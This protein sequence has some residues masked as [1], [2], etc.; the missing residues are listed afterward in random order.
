MD[1]PRC[2]LRSDQLVNQAADLH[3]QG[4]L[5]AAES[6]Y[7]QV[8]YAQSDHF[9]V[10]HS[11]GV[12]RYQQGRF[13][14]ALSLIGA[15]LKNNPDFP[16]ALVNY[17][18]VLQALDR[19]V[20]ALASYDRALWIKPDYAESLYN[21]GNA[22]QDY[23]RGEI[24]QDLYCTA[25]DKALAIQP[26]AVDVLNHR[27]TILRDLKRLAEALASYDKALEIKP[28]YAEALNNRGNVLRDL[29]RSD[30]PLAS[31]DKGFIFSPAR[32]QSPMTQQDYPGRLQV[33]F[34]YGYATDGPVAVRQPSNH[35]KQQM[36]LAVARAFEPRR[37]VGFGKVR[38]GRDFDGGYV[39]VDDFAGVGAALSCGI[40][41]DA[42]WDL[43]IAK[44]N[45]PV[46]QFDHTIEKAPID[47][48]L[49]TLHKQRVV[50]VDGPGTLCLDTMA[51][52]FLSGCERAILK[53]DIEGDEWLAFSAV[54]TET[55]G[56]F[57]Q[58]I[59]EFHGLYYAGDPIW[60]KRFMAG[61]SK[62]RAVFEVV[63][64]HGNNSGPFANIANVIL[65]AT[66]EVTFANRA[67]Y[68]FAESDEVFPTALDRPN[69]P[70]QPEMRL[71]SF[72][73]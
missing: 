52:R 38:L 68:Q 25:Y 26:R 5:A 33:R 70:N 48:P 15:A 18:V 56:K 60:H 19:P 35:E 7:L 64:V 62:L 39:Q 46:H 16:P 1:E 20:E 31:Y 6:L 44:R 67:C 37:V 8:L 40:S 4:K 50:S 73:F 72:R 17:A 58:I 71:G 34:R 10:L 27:G 2:I 14:E 53:I 11:L 54:S 42:S 3:R 55:L 65:P 24:I 22:L 21:R 49:L 63:H 57:S 30:Q 29:K 45:I 47:H 66:L 9:D 51:E 13:T 59:C 61:L 43:E 32:Q 69:A 12:L 41:D 23:Y 28:D 36:A